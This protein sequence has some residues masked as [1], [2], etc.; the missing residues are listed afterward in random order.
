MRED[1]WGEESGGEE[2][3]EDINLKD[4]LLGLGVRFNVKFERT[5]SAFDEG[6]NGGEGEWWGAVNM[7]NGSV[8]SEVEFAILCSGKG[9]LIINVNTMYMQ[10]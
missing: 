4:L 3:G 7:C 1:E 5:E 6:V 9:I 2:G 10:G 8:L